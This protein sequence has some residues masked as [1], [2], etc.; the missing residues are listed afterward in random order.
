VKREK[1]T[2]SKLR[3][4]ENVGI[5]FGLRVSPR[6]FVQALNLLERT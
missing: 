4:F 2:E 6:I 5:S 3:D 1:T